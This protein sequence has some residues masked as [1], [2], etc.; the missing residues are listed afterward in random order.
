VYNVSIKGV[1]NPT[2][3]GGTGMF[4]MKSYTGQNLL[5][6]NAI[7]GVI[8]IASAINLLTNTMVSLKS[9][10]VSTAGAFT[11][12]LLK[13]K[14]SSYI[15]WNSYI[16][17]TIPVSS[18]FVLN[19][20]PS[21]SSYPIYNKILPGVLHCETTGSNGDVIINGRFFNYFEI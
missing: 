17:I 3:S 5:D 13:F 8:G 19:K 16:K 7:F 10:G 15:P 6:E 14:I 12:Y 1:A 4:I 18:G 21:C 9:G 20:F 2:S 11:T